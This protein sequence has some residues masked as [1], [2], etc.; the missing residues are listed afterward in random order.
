MHAALLH[1]CKE[2]SLAS[3]GTPPTNSRRL[4]RQVCPVS[5]HPQMQEVKEELQTCLETLVVQLD[6]NLSR[7]LLVGK[8]A[9]GTRPANMTFSTMW[10]WVQEALSCFS[11]C[12]SG[13]AR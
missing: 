2:R 11:A 13:S 5:D 6:D 8:G 9:S 7:I 4:G 1:C 12:S 3:L 10:F